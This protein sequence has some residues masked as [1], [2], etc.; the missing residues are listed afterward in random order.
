MGCYSLMV[1]IFTRRHLSFAG[2]SAITPSFYTI[3][4]L[5]GDRGTKNRSILLV[6]VFTALTLWEA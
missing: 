4:G 5:K 2:Y 1:D 3:V 6:L